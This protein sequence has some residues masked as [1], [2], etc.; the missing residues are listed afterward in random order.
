[1]DRALVKL[2]RHTGKAKGLI[3]DTEGF[4]AFDHIT[5]LP[6]FRGL[7]PSDLYKIVRDDKKG[8]LEL[9]ARPFLQVRA[10]QGH[11]MPVC[12]TME[13]VHPPTMIH[14]TDNR[15]WAIIQRDGLRLMGRQHVHAASAPTARA[16]LRA[17]STVL[18]YLNTHAMI[19]YGMRIVRS[20][21][22]VL[23]TQG[24]HGLICPCFFL[25]AVDRY[26]GEEQRFCCRHHVV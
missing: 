7:Q 6:R 12:P 21:N 20:V 26:S 2:L 14:G 1:M 11:S 24:D 18:V 17:S 16:G 15:A 22:G 19:S 13:V 23:L 3:I 25:R 8:R 10:V 9:R 5:R 4:V